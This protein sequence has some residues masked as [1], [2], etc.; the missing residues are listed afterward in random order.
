MHLR[1]NGRDCRALVDTGCTDNIIYAP[2]CEQWWRNSVTVTT[3]SGD[4]FRCSG[5]GSVEVVTATDQRA[6]VD[7]LVV[8]K[9]PLGVE[10]ILGMSG[11]ARLGGVSV[12][13]PSQVRFCGAAVL[14][15]LGADAP[16]F[17]VRFDA[18]QRKWTVAWKWADGS[19]PKCLQN[20]VP[21]YSVPSSARG[22]FDQ[23]LET[24]VENGWLVPY[25]EQRLGPPLGLVPLMAVCQHN[26]AKV[27]P[28]LDFR[29]LNGHL[30]AHTADADVCADQLRKWRRHGKNVAVVDLKKAY[31]QIHLDERLWPYQTVEIRG[32]RYCLVRLGF[33]LSLAPLV[34][35]AVVRSVLAQDPQIERAVLSYVDDLLVDEDVAS[36]ERVVNHFARYGLTCKAPERVSDGARLLGLRVRPLRGELHWTRDNAVGP[37]PSRLTRRGVFAWCGR[38]VA[39]LPVCGWLRPAAAW[40]KRRANA[41]TR[42]WDDA[43]DDPVLRAQVEYVADRIASDDP[44]R[45]VWCVSG[46]QAV[47]WTDA[48]SLAAGVVLETADGGAVEDA[49]WLR[50]E[51]AASTHINMAELDAAV[52]GVNL[53]IAWGM[54]TVEL[55]TDSATVHRWIDD[56]L[57][58]R[59]RLRTKAHGEML[60]RRRV[61]LIRQLADEMTLTLTVTLVRSEENRADALTR[62][63]KEWLR[64]AAPARAAVGAA[65][66][67]DPWEVSVADGRRRAKAGTEEVTAAIVEVHERAGHPG[68]RR[69]QYF[70]RRDI[71]PSITRSQ[72]RAVVQDCDICRSI[73]PAPVTWRHGSLEVPETWQRLAIDVTHYQAKSY[74]TVIDCG[75]SRFGL[76]RL[77]RRSDA[78][79][80][81]AQ[82]EAILCERGAPEEILCDN[83]TVFRGRQFAAFVEKWGVELRFRAAYEP[84]GNGIV[85]RHH[86]TVKVI[87]ARK[88]CSIAEAVH[89]YNVSPRESDSAHDAPAGRVYRY[90]VRDCVRPAGGRAPIS[91]AETDRSRPSARRETSG[92]APG[93]AVWVRRRGTRCTDTSQPGVVSALVSP[94]VVDVDGVPHHVRNLR[95]RDVGASGDGDDRAEDGSAGNEPPLIVPTQPA[96]VPTQRVCDAAS[97]DEVG[98]A[99]GENVPVQECGDSAADDRHVESD[100]TVCLRRSLR[101]RRQAQHYGVPVYY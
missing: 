23:E 31:L 95:H 85:E 90:T 98:G 41:V 2:F 49:C 63:P 70:A 5:T 53:A 3:M 22:E 93:D 73:D 16:D 32:Q 50:R 97:N 69:T 13:S 101:E 26:K 36:A 83:D 54:R 87:A 65:V 62:V 28:V 67:A 17:S 78:E 61:D 4:S 82:L 91:G 96:H 11:I 9:R 8:D 25:D 6:H 72:V 48:S 86:R 84:G 100:D 34:M 35:K 18:A 71:D 24:W 15:P 19:G 59:A 57:S 68:I 75:P 33:G 51:A 45:G 79:S 47:V 66:V 10:L 43:T 27:R 29:E 21:Q 40:L 55:R 46:D 44:A 39:H 81:V 76:W 89:L 88:Q 37:P 12:Q 99:D 14:P 74:L 80:V 42:G 1:I 94:Q 58:G 38:L 52:K 64:D 20:T 30:T 56:A 7:V 92:F 60:I 77:L